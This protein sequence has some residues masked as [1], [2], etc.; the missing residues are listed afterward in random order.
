[1]LLICLLRHK[2]T[3]TELRF[4]FF[5]HLQGSLLFAKHNLTRNLECVFLAVLMKA[6]EADFSSEN[7][8]HHQMAVAFGMNDMF[9]C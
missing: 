6:S 2:D 8:G 3:L 7:G 4:F 5:E 9:Y 1:M